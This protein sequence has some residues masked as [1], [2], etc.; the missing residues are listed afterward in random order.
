MKT[1]DERVGESLARRRFVM[2]LMVL[3]TLVAATLAVIGVY[4]VMAYLVSQGT[5]DMGIRL[6]LGA[7]PASILRLILSRGVMLGVVGVV[8]GLAGAAGLTRLMTSVL[9]GVAPID[10]LTF[11]SVAMLLLAAVLAACLIPARRAAR[12]DPTVALRSE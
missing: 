8:L 4:G 7:S 5:R 9:F 10:A 6:A 3:L 11:A 2:T 1:M 12:T